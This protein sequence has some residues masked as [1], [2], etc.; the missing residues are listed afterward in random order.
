MNIQRMKK[1]NLWAVIILLCTLTAIV[2]LVIDYQTKN[3][4]LAEAKKLKE[5]IE[6]GRFAEETA[7]KRAYS[8][9]ANNGRIPEPM[10]Y[11]GNAGMEAHGIGEPSKASK[12]RPRRTNAGTKSDSTEI[13]PGNEPMGS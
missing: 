7:R 11:N 4:L 5:V 3:S 6:N 9:S 10:V 1:E 13:P 8:D 12:P 2:V